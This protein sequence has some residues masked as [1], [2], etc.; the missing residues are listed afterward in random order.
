MNQEAA[1][2]RHQLCRHLD[3]GL[4]RTV[5][6]ACVVQRPPSVRYFVA[7][8][9]RD[10]GAY[11]QEFLMSTHSRRSQNSAY[12]TGPFTMS[13]VLLD[14]P[15]ISAPI[16]QPLNNFTSLG[17]CFFRPSFCRCTFSGQ[18]AAAS[19]GELLLLFFRTPEVFL[20]SLLGQPDSQSSLRMLRFCVQ[21]LADAVRLIGP[22]GSDFSPVEAQ[23]VAVE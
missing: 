13:P 2:T 14:L 9:W 8:T 10:G 19:P 16:Y 20:V 17:T 6:N 23:S 21:G 5:R 18:E 12:Q 11:H 7:V 3:L 15:P 1:L 4:S 22:S